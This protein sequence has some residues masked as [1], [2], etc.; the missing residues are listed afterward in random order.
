MVN[1]SVIINLNTDDTVS[2][3]E[4]KAPQNDSGNTNNEDNAR[5]P[6]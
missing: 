6:K 1:E 5:Y 2:F 3:T 4:Q